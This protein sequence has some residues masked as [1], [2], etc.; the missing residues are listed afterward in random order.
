MSFLYFLPGVMPVHVRSPKELRTV[1]ANAGLA[2]L[3]I[4]ELADVVVTEVDK[5]VEGARMRGVIIA[6]KINGTNPPVDNFG[7]GQMWLNCGKFQVGCV[8]ESP[9]GPQELI[10]RTACLGYDVSDSRG[11]KWTVPIARSPVDGNVN[12]PSDFLF[13][14]STGVATCR[15]KPEFDWLWELT[16]RLQDR[17]H[18]D[19]QMSMS[20][21]AA[22]AIKILG[23]NYCIGPAE[24]NLLTQVGWPVVD[25]QTAQ[26][27]TLFCLDNPILH[28]QKKK[29]LT[30]ET[31]SPPGD[32]SS[33]TP[34]DPAD[35]PATAPAAA[36]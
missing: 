2:Y 13:D 15:L 18:G 21:L 23:V 16:G 26:S 35:S 27:I 5:T 36:N 34:G 11:R 1:L 10:R 25:S 4:R 31:G 3:G 8:V 19:G 6:R 12:L 30:P 22:A 32:G 29:A 28:E 17:W 7:P 20:E 33:G 14:L 24:S 9:P